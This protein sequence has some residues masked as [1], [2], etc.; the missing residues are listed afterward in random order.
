MTAARF[1]S[2]LSKETKARCT[3]LLANILHILN[4]WPCLSCVTHGV[5]VTDNVGMR[6]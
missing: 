3:N 2:D 5:S 1:G 4:E 6:C